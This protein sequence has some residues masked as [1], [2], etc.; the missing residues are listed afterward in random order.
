M[1]FVKPATSKGPEVVQH[2]AEFDAQV[3]EED[4]TVSDGEVKEV[5][6]IER[7]HSLLRNIF[8]F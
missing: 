8:L 7:K 2:N 6:Q 4:G 5:N 1:K 3:R